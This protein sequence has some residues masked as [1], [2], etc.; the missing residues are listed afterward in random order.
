MQ[1]ILLTVIV[2]ENFI[3]THLTKNNYLTLQDQ[4][5]HRNGCRDLILLPQKA[6]GFIGRPFK[7]PGHPDGG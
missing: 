3:L 6:Y 7:L 2:Q 5:I 4:D 1:I